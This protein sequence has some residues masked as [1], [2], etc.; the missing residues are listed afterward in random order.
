MEEQEEEEAQRR[1]VHLAMSMFHHVG[2]QGAGRGPPQHPP[3]TSLWP[4]S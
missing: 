4:K 3:S 1:R 2:V